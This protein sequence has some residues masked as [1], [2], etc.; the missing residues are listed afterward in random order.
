[1]GEPLALQDIFFSTLS[2]AAIV[3]TGALYAMFFALAR[4]H[5]SVA[6]E[7][8][9]IVAFALLAAAVW[10]LI[11]SLSLS[12]FWI[13]VTAV[14]LI[15]YFVAPRSIWRLCLGTHGE[16]DATPQQRST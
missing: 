10:V 12:G 9:S 2:G 5:R 15:G 14:M 4:L 11:R 7:I 6:F 8:A 13:L 3:L 1:M 16:E